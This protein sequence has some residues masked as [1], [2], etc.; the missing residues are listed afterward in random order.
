[1]V[2][3]E[4][5]EFEVLSKMDINIKA[6][7][8]MKTFVLVALSG[9]GVF[10][11][12]CAAQYGYQIW[13]RAREPVIPTIEEAVVPTEAPTPTPP[14]PSESLF[15]PMI[16]EEEPFDV[17]NY[18]DFVD[19]YGTSDP[20]YDFNEDGIVDDADFEIFKQRYQQSNQ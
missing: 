20:A 4:R 2:S 17:L 12:V 5:S 1:M 11:T 10:L 6:Q 14:P 19:A 9:V 18:S 16:G 7:K 15:E 8:G 3:E 13:T